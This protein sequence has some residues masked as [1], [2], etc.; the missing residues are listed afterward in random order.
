M[1]SNFV[2]YFV[3]QPVKVRDARCFFFFSYYG[4]V[5]VFGP[6][7]LTVGAAIDFY[8]QADPSF[9]APVQRDEPQEARH[10]SLLQ[11]MANSAL[12]VGVP[13]EGLWARTHRRTDTTHAHNEIK[14]IKATSLQSNKQLW[15]YEQAHL[16]HSPHPALKV[17]ADKTHKVITAL[18]HI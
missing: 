12:R 6:S 4:C 9:L 14:Y 11:L 15:D 13:R 2:D 5:C 10:D 1:W 18:H 7:L 8:A 17:H 3:C 16:F